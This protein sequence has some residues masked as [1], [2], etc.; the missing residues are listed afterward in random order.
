M[1]KNEKK[2]KKKKSGETI[3][4]LKAIKVRILRFEEAI[5]MQDKS[6]SDYMTRLQQFASQLYAKQPSETKRKG[7]I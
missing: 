7:V 6:L 1:A 4:Y 2:K 3:S 5:Q